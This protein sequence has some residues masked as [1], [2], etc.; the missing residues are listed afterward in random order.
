MTD[1]TIYWIW[2]AERLGAANKHAQE[3]LNR[4][5]SVFEIYRADEEQVT[6]FDRDGNEIFGVLFD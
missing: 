5:G 2:L 6:G 4:F 3:L 1:E